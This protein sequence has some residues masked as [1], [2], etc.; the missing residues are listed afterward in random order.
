MKNIRI[1]I[2]LKT[3][4]HSF[5]G[6]SEKSVELPEGSSVADAIRSTGLSEKIANICAG[7]MNGLSVD[8]SSVLKDNDC[9]LLYMKVVV[10]G[11]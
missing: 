11:G 2:K 5:A 9:L 3:P 1:R 8:D 10:L 7:Q 6:Y 4:L